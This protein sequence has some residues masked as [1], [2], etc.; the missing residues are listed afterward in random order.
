MKDYVPEF[1]D[2]HLIE[3]QDPISYPN[4]LQL[5][6]VFVERNALWVI[7]EYAVPFDYSLERTEQ[8]IRDFAKC[9]LQERFS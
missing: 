5:L 8:E 6:A 7:H 2:G 4:N 1:S 9:F 3:Y